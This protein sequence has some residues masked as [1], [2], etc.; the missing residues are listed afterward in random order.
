MEK[1]KK[2]VLLANAF[3]KTLLRNKMALDFALLLNFPYSPEA[4]FV[5]VYL[6]GRYR[7]L[8][9]LTEAVNEG[10]N[11]VSMNVY[12]GDF[13]FE[14]DTTRFE[15]GRVYI[16]TKRGMRFKIEEP[17]EPTARQISSVRGYLLQIESAI[18][19]RDIEKISRYID[20]PSFVDFYVLMEHF[21]DVDGWFSSMYFYLKDGKMY[22]G[23]VW[24]MDLSSG[25]VSAE[26]DEDKY[27]TYCNLPG[28]G[29]GSHDSAD[30]IWMR[31]GW[32]DILMDCESFSSL[33]ASLV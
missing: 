7:G 2:W 5:E 27:R 23:P 15:I 11:R 14:H 16:E 3:D 13:L 25:N 12:K 30:G 31:Y 28:F 29:T 9:L 17:K 4:V 10:K 19:S 26:V 24:D 18:E 1:S 22:A 8:Y 20:V 33:C 21:K 32:L 6:D